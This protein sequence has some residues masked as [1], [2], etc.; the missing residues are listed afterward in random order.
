M[1]KQIMEAALGEM[2]EKG[3]HGAGLKKLALAAKM[4]QGSFYSY[5]KSKDHLIQ[6]AIAGALAARREDWKE[7]LGEDGSGFDAEIRNY[8]SEEARD[9]PRIGRTIAS[10]AGEIGRL[11]MEARLA[12]ECELNKL[13]GLIAER[14]PGRRIRDRRKEAISIYCLMI[15]AV[16]LSRG[17]ATAALS[18]EILEAARGFALETAAPAD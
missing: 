14:L 7:L 2:R 18:R 9:N 3:I 6:E 11:S 5:F 15:G 4:R 17:V 12:I 1:R 8:L 13:F 10:V 16:Q